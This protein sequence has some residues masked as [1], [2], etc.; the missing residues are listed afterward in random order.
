MDTPLPLC[1]HCVSHSTHTH[2]RPLPLC[3]EAWKNYQD[4]L[5]QQKR[6]AKQL[7]TEDGPKPGP[8]AAAAEAAAAGEAPAAAAA[9]GDVEMKDAAADAGASSSGPASVVGALTG[10][11]G[12]RAGGAGS[13]CSLQRR[14][15]APGAL[16]VRAKAAGG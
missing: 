14:G 15:L 7:K 11:V 10:E 12:S 2:V 1:C 3:R 13:S 4:T 16:L 8:G 9:A 6:T 5:A